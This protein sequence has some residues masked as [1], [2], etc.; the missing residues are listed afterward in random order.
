MRSGRLLPAISDVARRPRT[1]EPGRRPRPAA[2]PRPARSIGLG[3][4]CAP[5]APRC[6]PARRAP[7]AGTSARRKPSRAA[8]AS[9]RAVWPTWRSSPPRPTSPQA[10]RSA[11]TRHAG[12]GRREGQRHGQVGARL[13]DLAPRRP[14]RRRRRLRGGRCRARCSSTASSSARRPP[15][16]PCAE[17]RGDGERPGATSRPAPRPAA[18]GAPRSSGT[19]TEPGTPGRRSAR[20]SAAGSG[21]PAEPG[22]GH[23]EQAELVGGAEAVLHRPQQAQGVVAVALEGQHGVDHVLEHP[24]PGQR[25]V[26][27]DVADEHDGDAR[28]PWP[29]APA[30]G[31]TP[32][33]GPTEPGRRRRARGRARSGSSRRRARSGRTSSRWASTSGSDVS[34]TSHRPVGQRAQA[35]G[36]EPHLLAPTPRPRRR[37]RWPGPGQRRRHLEQQ[38]GLA[39]ARLAAEQGDRA[40]HQAAAAAPGRARRCRWAGRPLGGVDL[41][42]SAPAGRGPATAAAP[43]TPATAAPRRGCSTPRSPGTAPPTAATPRRTPPH[44]YTDLVRPM[45]DRYRGRVTAPAAGGSARVGTACHPGASSDRGTDWGCSGDPRRDGARG[46]NGDARRHP[47]RRR[48]RP[49]PRPPTA[50]TPGDR[51]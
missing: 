44:R 16:T 11:G 36:P 20:N 42:R 18:G 39:D 17:R 2:A 21:T 48:P 30:G 29:P 41:G 9:R 19:T 24:G 28:A 31:R 5:G 14:P 32:A 37:A 8:S 22:V 4:R 45:H 34:A 47:G 25:A 1:S 6:R 35:L 13:G 49:R 23:L 40:G 27:G 12:S 10:T 50:S 26:L 43:P 46:G 3:R 38:G 7:S 15:S 51:G 33:P